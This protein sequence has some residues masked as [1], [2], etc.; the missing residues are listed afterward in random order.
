MAKLQLS[1]LHV[2]LPKQSTTQ[3][4]DNAKESQEIESK[5]Q[6]RKGNLSSGIMRTINTLAVICLLG[7]T[8]QTAQANGKKKD[9]HLTPVVCFV[10]TGIFLTDVFDVF[11]SDE[12]SWNVQ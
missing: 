4:S 9:K 3:I 7:S 10:Q 8:V 11:R 5:L 6:S 1:L 12:W 2:S